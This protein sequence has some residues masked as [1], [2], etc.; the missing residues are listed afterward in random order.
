MPGMNA[1]G[2][3]TEANTSAIPTTGPESSFIA[4]I[5][6]SFGASPSSIWRCTPSTTTIASS[7]TKPIART[8]PNRD[9]QHRDQG[10]PPVLQEEVHHKNDKQNRN[11]Q[12]FDNVPHA[13]SDRQSLV[14]RYRIVDIFGKAL[15]HPAHELADALCGLKG[16][17]SRKL[18]NRN[19]G[20]GL[21]IQ[22]ANRAVVL[23]AQLDSSKVFHAHDPAIRSFANNDA[24]EFFGRC[25]TA[26][27]QQRIGVLLICGSRLATDLASRI[28]LALSLDGVSHVR[29]GDAQLRQLIGFYPEPHCI[30]AGPEDLRPAHAIGPADGVVE[31]DECIIRQKR[32]V[33][34]AVGRVQAHQQER[35][36][37]RL[38]Q[39]DPIAGHL[40]RKL[41]VCQLLTRLRKNEIHVGISLEIKI[42]EQRGLRTIGGVYGIH[43]F[44]IVDA[45]HLLFDRRS[46]RLLKSLC[47][48][49]GVVRLQPDFRR[50]NVRKLCDW[51]KRNRD[52]ANYNGKDRDHNRD[53]GASDEKTRHG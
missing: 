51:Q 34:G 16:V 40:G 17:R 20:A 53:D 9:S 10:G 2:T 31:I 15:L 18:V 42:D 5:A 30:L 49:T 33:A 28:Y 27:C 37:G 36:G 25:Q 21:A 14:E 35:S 6:A 1:V 47:V 11:H 38:S 12:R 48:G 19:D 13:F 39:R 45:G 44:H 3:N 46:D 29:Y 26:L 4:F 24:A 43:V 7:T 41:T 23:L 8:R 32:R 50:G 52:R 22:P